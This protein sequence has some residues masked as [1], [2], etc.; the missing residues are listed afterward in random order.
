MG[1]VGGTEGGGVVIE[2]CELGPLGIRQGDS[3]SSATG[4]R[5]SVLVAALALAG[6]HGVP[7]ERLIETMWPSPR[8]P[9]TARQSLANIVSRLRKAHG[10]GM[11]ESTPRG[12][13]LGDTVVS[14]RH[15]FELDVNRAAETV[16][17]DPREAL[18]IVSDALQRWR[19]EPWAGL[20]RP[21]S[22]EGDRAH[23]HAVRTVAL[24]VRAAALLALE[25]PD[26]ALPMLQEVVN[27]NPLDEDAALLLASTLG[28]EGRRTEALRVIQSA[29]KALLASGLELDADLQDLEVRL[30]GPDDTATSDPD[31]S[32]P[33]ADGGATVQ[34]RAF[35][36]SDI[37]GSTA[38]WEADSP[39]MLDALTIHD[40]LVR[41]VI[42]SANG[43][44]FAHT[45]DGV[46][47]CFPTSTE[48][49]VAAATM[50]SR[51]AE[52]DWPNGR[53]I[54]V[55][56][57]LHAG[58]AHRIGEN[59]FGPTV[60]RTARVAD[61]AV[62]G[63]I[64]ATTSVAD[65]AD[66]S[67]GLDRIAHG[68]FRLKGIDHE[69]ELVELAGPAGSLGPPR[70]RSRDRT[71]ALPP[72]GPVVGRDRDLA[73]IRS[74]FT[75][76]SPIVTI[77]GIGG[78]GKTTLARAYVG[79][80]LATSDD[81]I[82]WVDVL[83]VDD[84]DELLALIDRA[85]REVSGPQAS[86]RNCAGLLVL[87]NCEHVADAI[88]DVLTARDARV[89]VVVTSRRPLRC[90]GE[91]LVALRP[92]NTNDDGP[93]TSL[94]MHV[95]RRAD[96][97]R[98]TTSDERAAIAQ[99]CQ[100]V[101]GVPLAIE[102]IAARCRSL[103]IEHAEEL[104]AGSLRGL[105]DR[106]RSQRHAS[107]EEVIR[108]SFDRLRPVEARVFTTL[109]LLRGFDFATVRGMWS[110]E[111]D[112]LDLVDALDVLV[113]ENLV[114]FDGRRYGVLEPIRLFAESELHQWPDRDE[115]E[116]RYVRAVLDLFSGFQLDR[117]RLHPLATAN[118]SS[119]NLDTANAR[120][121]L[122][123][124]LADG[125]VAMAGQLLT[126]AGIS[127]F[128]AGEFNLLRSF[129]RQLLDLTRQTASASDRAAL[130]FAA[131]QSSWRMGEPAIALDAL[132]E[133]VELYQD[134]NDP[135]GT[136]LS[137]T[138]LAAAHWDLGDLEA[139][140]TTMSAA[141]DHW[142]GVDD[143]LFGH[144]GAPVFYWNH[145]RNPALCRQLVD[146]AVAAMGEDALDPHVREVR[147]LLAIDDEDLD[148]ALSDLLVVTDQWAD[149]NNSGCLAHALEAAALWA[150]RSDRVELAQAL[151]DALHGHRQRSGIPPLALETMTSSRV[152]EELAANGAT[153]SPPELD[154]M[155]L[156]GAHQLFSNE[157]QLPC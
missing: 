31:G 121:A 15:Q 122:D 79:Q 29:R 143:T 7:S 87:D 13:R 99:L 70:V 4:E 55:R 107:I 118:A 114:H 20:E 83:T 57:G 132:V 113:R 48:A 134:A 98:T 112:T 33:T 139:A 140:S 123:I 84:G 129:A 93:A 141:L 92:L 76:G 41:A 63:Q 128:E 100:I 142:R 1:D 81:D 94:F 145:D 104:L 51:L 102:M 27:L 124:C 24:R 16:E 52:Q 73:A 157:A 105:T 126:A 3:W 156:F 56:I 153:S 42:E 97:T 21:D 44:I 32:T 127:L 82:W 69:I 152:D 45:G 6:P 155:G 59:W 68:R 130:L 64:L 71:N 65:T 119:P 89:R 115:W 38:H 111:L 85:V 36:F 14:D 150:V 40:R 25:R 10:D 149:A 147:A 151:R 116:R 154:G 9:A 117:C 12:Y 103:P 19:G 109:S 137:R 88:A 53:R 11:I 135:F 67:S 74:A 131:G 61:A 91:H 58:E 26:E 47:A 95:L 86:F 75:T 101:A 54:E 46:A 35:L 96:H 5:T 23:L 43:A 148:A 17:L 78:M 66:T 77:T 62:P 90:R 2:L 80:H 30:L 37:A 22:V 133:S 136:A 60:T 72:D 50:V 49:T 138:F 28:S 18:A 106:A 110:E 146:R 8:Q 144:T 125:D 34:H 39:V 120:N 108:W